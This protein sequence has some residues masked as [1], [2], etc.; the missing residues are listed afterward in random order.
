MSNTGY[1]VIRRCRECHADTKV[2]VYVLPTV[3]EIKCRICGAE[4]QLP[5]F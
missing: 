5:R 1:D 2:N 4:Y 3:V